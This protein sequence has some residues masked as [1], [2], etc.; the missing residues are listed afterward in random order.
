MTDGTITLT[1]DEL[2]EM[3][4][5]AVS[6]ALG[7]VAGEL[8]LTERRR[9]LIRNWH[10]SKKSDPEY[11]ARRRAAN[12]ETARKRA[13]ELRQRYRDDPE[14]AERQRQ[15]VRDHRARKKAEATP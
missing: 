6:E 9:E 7:S 13:P 5:R 14:F 4:E 15:Y 10:R 1:L 11:M 12:R 3:I 8:E 2:A